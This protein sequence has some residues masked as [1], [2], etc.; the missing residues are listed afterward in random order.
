MSCRRITRLPSC[1]IDD[2]TSLAVLLCDIFVF[3][4]YERGIWSSA[5]RS[6]GGVRSSS[7]CLN[8][9][10]CQSYWRRGNPRVAV[11][12]EDLTTPGPTNRRSHRRASWASVAWS[13]REFTGEQARP[14]ACSRLPSARIRFRSVPTPCS[15]LPVFGPGRYLIIW[16][17]DWSTRLSFTRGSAAFPGVIGRSW[18]YPEAFSGRHSI[19]GFATREGWFEQSPSGNE[20][21]RIDWPGHVPY[22]APPLIAG[23][24]NRRHRSARHS[25]NRRI[26]SDSGDDDWHPG[27]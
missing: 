1:R 23:G 13:S 19:V 24:A 17:T 9:L 11:Y 18:R 27:N 22:F 10:C 4:S 2:Q 14:V 20:L 26:R 6:D 25:C 16:L 7:R 15:S 8:S 3:P 12:V 21:R 5:S